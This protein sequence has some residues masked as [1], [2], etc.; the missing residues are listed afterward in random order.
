MCNLIGDWL[1][2]H[3]GIVLV[4]K[5]SRKEL[6]E[7]LACSLFVCIMYPT[8]SQPSALRMWCVRQSGRQGERVCVCYWVYRFDWLLC[9]VHYEVMNLAT[10][11]MQPSGYF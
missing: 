4:V 3:L 9:G 10:F 7:P 1:T 11:F 5:A 8:C 2:V 6:V